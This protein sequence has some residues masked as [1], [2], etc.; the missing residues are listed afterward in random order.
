MHGKIATSWQ[1]ASRWYNQSQGLGGS[2]YYEKIVLPKTL[3]LLELKPAVRILDLGCGQG[4]LERA[5]SKE[6]SYLGI[7]LAKDLVRYAIDHRLAPTHQFVVGDI[8]KPLP[9]AKGLLY[10]KIAV[11]LVMQNLAGLTGL[12]ANIR[13]HLAN[14]GS[15]VI[16]LNHPYFRLPRQSSWQI[17]EA[18]KIQYRRINRY[19]TNMKV[20]IVMNPGQKEGKKITWSFHYPLWQISQAIFDHG[21]VIDKIEEWIS[22]KKSVGKAAKMENLARQEFPLFMAIRITKSVASSRS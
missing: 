6:N 17:D 11:I 22:D 16:V 12:F 15:A 2:Y 21:L 9:I 18:N 5:I 10:D 8:T 20:P 7:D 14:R 13:D 4:I 1:P 3:E 19:Q